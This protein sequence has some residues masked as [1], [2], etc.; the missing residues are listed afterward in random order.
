MEKR[1]I[2][3]GRRLNIPS[4]FLDE[5][6]LSAEWQEV[7]LTIEYGKICIKKFE[8]ENIQ[9]KPYIGIVREL[10][11]L[12]RVVIPAEYLRVLKIEIGDIIQLRLEDKVIKVQRL[13]I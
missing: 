12:R 4:K 9:K 7:E 3:K 8:R 2:T 13:K 6:E 11:D 1:K 5:L 10:D